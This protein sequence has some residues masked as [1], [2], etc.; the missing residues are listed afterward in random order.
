MRLSNFFRAL[1]TSPKPPLPSL[2]SSTHSLVY[3]EKPGPKPVD[4]RRLGQFGG[5]V[6]EVEEGSRMLTGELGR[7]WT[8]ILLRRNS[9]GIK[10]KALGLFLASSLK[11]CKIRYS[12]CSDGSKASINPSGE[13]YFCGT[14][15]PKSI[16]KNTMPRSHTSVL[17]VFLV[18]TLS[19]VKEALLGVIGVSSWAN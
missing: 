14:S 15:N 17:L 7:E 2:P 13:L 12:S 16:C 18:S 8:G 3:R 1:T 4:P 5:R 11:N 19:E 10:S 6:S 9:L